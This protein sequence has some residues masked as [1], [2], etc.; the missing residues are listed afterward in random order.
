MDAVTIL[1]QLWRHRLVVAVGMLIAALLATLMTYKVTP[2][3]P[4]KFESRQ[5]QVGIASAE[6]LVDSPS[7]QVADLGGGA[8]KT[9][10]TALTAR[11]R[12]LANLMATSPLKDEIARRAGVDPRVLIATAPVIGPKLKPDAIENETVLD[13]RRTTTL[14]LYFNE[15]LPIVTADA[16]ATTPEVAARLATAAIEQLRIYLSSVAAGDKVPDARQLVLNPLGP[17]RFATVQRGPRRL[18]SA[19]AFLFILGAW[20]AGIIV[21]SRTARKWR[22]AAA[23]EAPEGPVPATPRQPEPAAL[24]TERHARGRAGQAEAPVA[25]ASRS[26]VRPP[27]RRDL[28]ELSELPERPRGRDTARR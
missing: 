14:T 16:Q 18:Y 15:T 3:V 4:P 17:A 24:R 28:T 25:G 20:C 11:A 7:S 26:K 23:R 6:V 8:V 21:I 12:L 2:G 13:D 9:D 27:Q 22:E 10:V 19:V 1:R 5:Y